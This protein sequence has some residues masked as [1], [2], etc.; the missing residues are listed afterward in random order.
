MGVIKQ[1]FLDQSNITFFR[2]QEPLR[3]CEQCSRGAPASQ[4]IQDDKKVDDDDDEQP[5]RLTRYTN[6]RWVDGVKELKCAHIKFHNSK[7][8]EEFR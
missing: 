7:P 1:G 6:L 2:S 8:L 3:T 4:T 5:A